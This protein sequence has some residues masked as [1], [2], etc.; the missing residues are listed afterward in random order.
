M[1]YLEGDTTEVDALTGIGAVFQQP[2]MHYTSHDGKRMKEPLILR[3]EYELGPTWLDFFKGS[4]KVARVYTYFYRRQLDVRGNELPNLLWLHGQDDGAGP[5]E[6][7]GEGPHE[8]DAPGASG[9]QA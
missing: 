9:A 6:D 1:Q 4:R 3:N 2:M 5:H 8:P 7:D